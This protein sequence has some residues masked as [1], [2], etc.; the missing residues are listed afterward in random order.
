MLGMPEH[1]AV[2]ELV[3]IDKA[4]SGRPV[5]NGVGFSL[6]RGQVVG[7]VGENGAGK[8]TLL[9]IVSGNLRP[10]GGRVL[11]NGREV[12]FRS[13][14]DATK[15][16][17]FHIY[18]DLALVPVLSV[19]ENVMLAHEQAFSRFGVI[20]NR[21]MRRKVEAIF[22]EFG[23]GHIDVRQPVSTFDFSTR[24]VI[25]I[26]KAFT[27]A[28]LLGIAEPIM[29]FDEPT[30]ALTGDEVDFLMELIARVRQRAA[31]VYV[32]HR[33]PEVLELCDVI[34]VL[35]DGA[36]VATL[37]AEGTQETELHEHMVGRKRGEFFYRE[38][39]QRQPDARC[40]LFV[41]N[42]RMLGAFE[43]IDLTVRSGEIVGVAGILGSGKSEL[44]RALAGDMPEATGS[45][46]IAGRKLERID[47]A[48]V[49]DAGLGYL[50]PDRRDGVIPVLS[51]A[52]N[53]T[54]A[55]LTR[56]GE[57]A[58]LDL[59]RERV[60]AARL[61]AR[62]SIRTAGAD[63]QIATLSGGN[64]Q[65]V[66]LARWL[67]RDARVLVLDNPT[68]GVDAGAK[69][70]I[71][72]LLRDIAATGVG[73]LVVSDDLPEVIGLSNRI[74][75]MRDGRVTAEIAAPAEAKPAE[76]DIVAHMV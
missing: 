2:L 25:E 19:F 34:H 66:L 36:V 8:S 17:V 16:G 70:E 73:M 52:E 32:S 69:E 37:P 41:Q 30:A 43:A 75:V 14:E 21:A 76:V 61:I 53:M 56:Q 10:D 40:A 22:A 33:L 9:K 11:V 1:S 13:Y 18:Q 51:V 31:I 50:P 57:S 59:A 65:K 38:Q 42:F 23:H 71:Y 39:R 35:K 27:L 4:F 29:L 48:N 28:D 3:G 58:V 68:N 20:D 49:S 54:L 63:A 15:A 55:R 62:L 60:D 47:L 26:V 5:L 64:Q 72:E 67:L 7:L 44:A 46:E 74:L 24:Q 45:I 12:S 6:S